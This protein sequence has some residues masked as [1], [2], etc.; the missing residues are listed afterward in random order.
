MSPFY[1]GESANRLFGVYSPAHPARDRRKALLICAASFQDYMRT[2]RQLKQLAVKLSG[3]GIHVLRFDYS[4]CGDSAGSWEDTNVDDW[5]KSIEQ[6][7]VEL[8]ALSMVDN[9]SF[10]G[11]RFG[12]SL[13]NLANLNAFPAK[14]YVLWDPILDGEQ[15]LASLAKLQ[16]ELVDNGDRF[17]VPRRSYLE[18]HE[19]ELVGYP[20]S[21]ESR[22][23]IGK[24]NMLKEKWSANKTVLLFSHNEPDYRSFA[25][26]NECVELQSLSL[27]CHWDSL[28]HLE[29]QVQVPKLSS[30]LND[31]M[32]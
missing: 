17:A 16:R 4:G 21:A 25:E 31:F 24:V 5:V 14:R 3:Q 26:K 15:Y 28:K 27:P 12:A 1:F 6:A 30:I 23:Q 22:A 8:Q 9:L 32:Q 2:H 18:Q 10:L 13:L 29:S 19:M 11:V 7:A 20:V